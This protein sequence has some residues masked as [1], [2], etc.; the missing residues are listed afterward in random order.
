MT[1]ISSSM[2]QGLTSLLDINSQ[3]STVQTRLSTGKKLNSAADGAVQWLTVSDF[4]NRVSALQSVND[5]LTTALTQIKSASTALTSIRKSINDT[6]SQLKDA[7]TTQAA[8]NNVQAD[9]ASDAGSTMFNMSFYDVRGNI[10]TIKRTTL[11]TDANLRVNNNQ[12][13]LAAGAV[14]TISAGGN[15]VTIKIGGQADTVTGDG[16]AANP[17]VVRTIAD[18]SSAL[19]NVTNLRNTAGMPGNDNLAVGSINLQFTFTSSTTSTDPNKSQITFAQTSAVVGANNPD[20]GSLFV[21]NRNYVVSSASGIGDD[22]ISSGGAT[23]ATTMVLQGR[24]HTGT[25]GTATVAADP[26]RAVAA[27]ALVSLADSINALVKDARSNGINLLS[28]DDLTVVVNAENGSQKFQFTKNDG[29]PAQFT[30]EGLGINLTTLNLAGATIKNFDNDT[31]LNAAIAALQSA[32]DTS[33]TGLAKIG[34]WQAS[35]E[36]R[37]DFNAQISKILTSA[38][39]G[40]S[41]NDATADAAELASL[42]T[43]QT[44]ANSIL[45]IIKQGEQSPIQLLR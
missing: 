24:T 7:S 14:Y 18:L 44:F 9:V 17:R 33:D 12:T 28:G 8:V 42:Q 23:G 4:Q 26:K 43:R 15:S 27:N 11:L 36:T 45:S 37:T 22:T 2:Y 19:A 6:L 16:T 1:N 20:V 3:M 10:N 35:I 29:T 21:S 39:T 5:G 40:L 38:I 25:S 32:R 30:T 41:S 13:Q 31:D 34:T